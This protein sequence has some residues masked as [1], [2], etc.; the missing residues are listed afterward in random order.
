ML[1]SFFRIGR[2]EPGGDRAHLG[3]RLRQRDTGLQS[4]HRPQVAGAP[5]VAR[6]ERIVRPDLHVD[7]GR[8]GAEPGRQHSDHREGL[9]VQ[10]HRPPDG[11]PIAAQAALPEAVADD[12]DRRRVRAVV[13]GMHRAAQSRLNTKHVEDLRR[14]EGRGEAFRLA[15]PRQGRLPA[16]EDRES[17]E[18]AALCLPVEKVQV[19][20]AA[21]VARVLALAHFAERDDPIGVREGER[22]QQHRVHEREDRGVRADSEREHRDG[23]RREGGT[24]PE[25]PSGV[26]QILEKCR[27]R[28]TY[29]LRNAVIGSRREARAAGA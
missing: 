28:F 16:V 6:V 11:S 9:A 10:R 18:A 27:H 2:F 13:L 12:R 29:S 4:A 15:Q 1:P 14:D 3:A 25:H 8:R 19:G 26:A 5:R 20:G 21:R 23:D 7:L 17:V 24:A 22:P